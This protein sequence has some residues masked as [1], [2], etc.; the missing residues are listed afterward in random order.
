M[1]NPFMDSYTPSWVEK[2]RNVS[3]RKRSHVWAWFLAGVVLA[4]IILY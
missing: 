4:A 3:H 1:T 2:S